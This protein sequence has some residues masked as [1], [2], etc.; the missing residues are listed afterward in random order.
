MKRH[1][2]KSIKDKTILISTL[3]LEVQH[4]RRQKD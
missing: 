3:V 1:G 2:L 4:E